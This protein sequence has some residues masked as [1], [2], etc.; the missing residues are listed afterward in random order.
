MPRKA[1]RVAVAAIACA[2]AV[3]GAVTRDAA[4]DV[5]FNPGPCSPATVFAT[6]GTSGAATYSCESGRLKIVSMQAGMTR[7]LT[8]IPLIPVHPGDGWSATARLQTEAGNATSAR[9]AVTFFMS[10]SIYVPD[11]AVETAPLVGT[12]PATPQALGGKV[13]ATAAYMRIELRLGGPGTLRADA[14]SASV[15][16]VVP[17]VN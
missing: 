8:S 2:A 15:S 9:L 12:S 14:I 1:F 7:W 13:P 17:I 6:Y 10:P 5:F 4:A 3:G 11:S 16:H